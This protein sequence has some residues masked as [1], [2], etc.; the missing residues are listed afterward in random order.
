MTV[1]N[2]RGVKRLVADALTKRGWKH[3]PIVQTAY[4]VGGMSDRIAIKHGC[5]LAVETKFKYNKPSEVQ[6]RFLRTVR[7]QSCLA[8]VV[9]EKTIETFEDFLDAFD[10]ATEAQRLRKEPTD[11]VKAALTETMKVLIAPFMED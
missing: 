10:M 2:E 11:E 1:S 4:S 6:K 5:F 7:E 3:W 9:N 8:F